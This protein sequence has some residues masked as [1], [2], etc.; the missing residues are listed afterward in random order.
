[1]PCP[2]RIALHGFDR[3]RTGI[4]D[5]IG[6]AK[7]ACPM[8]PVYCDGENVAEII[9]VNVLLSNRRL[10]N[11]PAADIDDDIVRKLPQRIRAS[12]PSTAPTYSGIV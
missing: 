9:P 6:K 7:R 1:M 8:L 2:I 5:N 3:P 11:K 10:V 4:F 12:P